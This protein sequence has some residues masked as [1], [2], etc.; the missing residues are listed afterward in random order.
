M[1][2]RRSRPGGSGEQFRHELK[3]RISEEEHDLL[4]LRLP[5]FLA[6]DPHAEGGSYLIRSL[7]FDDYWNSAYEDKDSGVLMRKKYRIRIY[8]YSDR[9]IRLERKKKFERYIFKESAPLT[10]EQL[11]AILEGSFDFLLHSPHPLLQEFYVECV[12]SQMR[13]RTIVD[14]DRE[15]WVRDEGTVRLTF[16]RNVRAAVGSFDILDPSLPVLSVMPPG[17]MIMEVKFTEFLPQ[18][19]REILPPK[20]SELEA[21][22]KYVL[23]YEKT[24]YLRDYAYWEEIEK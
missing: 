4:K 2:R 21:Y 23:C 1:M 20:G 11:Y 10:R 5:A 9:I 17:E 24:R 3:Y 13:P 8:N 15:P 6:P 7:Y 19:V 16:D 18:I 14:Y 12:C 22:S